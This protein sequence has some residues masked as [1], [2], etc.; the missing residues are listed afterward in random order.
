MSTDP[1][2]LICGDGADRAA[3]HLGGD[4]RFGGQ[5]GEAGVF[6]VVGGLG[7]ALLHRAG[8][9]LAVVDQLANEAKDAAEAA[10]LVRA[11]PM[12]IGSVVAVEGWTT[13]GMNK[14]RTKAA[15]SV[16]K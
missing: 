9:L 10:G 5:T 11:A 7:F 8:E 4:F 2:A 6:G 14:T 12:G 13:A 3:A 15:R 1:L 16:K